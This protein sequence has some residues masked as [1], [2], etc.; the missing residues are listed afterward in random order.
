MKIYPFLLLF[1]ALSA[2]LRAQ[3]PTIITGNIRDAK[4]GE[5]LSLP[6]LRFLGQKTGVLAD[7][8]GKYK[9]ESIEKVDTL[10]CSYLG[11]QTQRVGIKRGETQEINFQLEPSLNELQVATVVAPRGRLPK[12]TLA[13]MLWREVVA[14]KAENQRVRS[15]YVG[16]EDYTKV[17]FDIYKFKYFKNLPPFKRKLKFVLNY[18]RQDDYSDFLPLMMKETL[19][20]VHLR[21]DPK[22]KRKEIVKLDRLSGI[23]NQSI[24]EGFN[25]QAEDVEIYD[26]TIQLV[27]K[28][29]VGPFSNI[30]NVTYRYFLTD[31]IMRGERMYYKLEFWGKS[32]QDLAFAGMAW[33]QDGSFAVEKIRMDVPKT[34]NINFLQSY[35][36]EQSYQQLADST[37]FKNSENVEAIFTVWRRKKKEP[38]SVVMR[39]YS[40]AFKIQTSDIVPDSVFSSD[41]VTWLKDAYQPADSL[42]D[43]LRPVPLLAHERGVFKMI[44]SIKQ[45]S[46]FKFWYGLGYTMSSAYIPAGPVEFGKFYEAVSWN[47]VEGTRLKLGVRT[48]NKL[49]KRFRANGYVAYGTLDQRWKFG[50]ATSWNIP[51]RKNLWE[52]IRGSYTYDYSLPGSFNRRSYDNI[53]SSMT[54][55]I[56]LTK[57]IR[58]QTAEA[59]YGRAW[60]RGLDNT[61]YLRHRIFYA[62]A[63]SGFDFSNGQQVLDKFSVSE[64][65]LNTH[66]G[67][68]EQFFSNANARTSLGSKLPVFYLDYTYR[69]M[70]N[71]LGRDLNSHQLALQVR[72]RLSWALGYTRYNLTASKIWGGVP[73]P[74]MNLHLGNGNYMYSRNAFNMMNESEFASDAYISLMFDHYFDGYFL[75][76]IPIIR[77]LGL[78]EVFSFRSVLGSVN[79]KNLDIMALPTGISAP[80][81]YAEIGFGIENIFKIVRIDF[82]WRLTQLDRPTSVP[83]GLKFALQPKF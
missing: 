4:T 1:F 50:A 9:I 3:N 11:Y 28:S 44:D 26:N 80:N 24:S 46:T 74:L 66:W 53:L 21:R 52:N 37:W 16:Y 19:S 33:I 73:Y 64:V 69:F 7:I 39:K 18:I 5:E 43:S 15:A 59:A 20:D 72:H 14:H 31:S 49:S 47:G 78:R 45:T 36:V 55:R 41:K 13:M 70:D 81:F 82:I 12:D 32:P 75:N 62:D 71:F 60:T 68:G 77:K 34:A 83:F 25:A 6:T 22:K 56:P 29:F 17:Q 10:I 51:N 35:R 63:N 40:E 57:L 65:Q 48:T 67:P 2:Q 54:R 27:G 76:K 42:W 8:A 38:V 23:E 30:G 58:M 79:P 61:V